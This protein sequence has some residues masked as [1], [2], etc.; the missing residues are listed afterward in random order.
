MISLHIFSADHRH[1]LL[2]NIQ[3]AESDCWM[4]LPKENH[5]P[6]INPEESVLN[7]DPLPPSLRL[8]INTEHFL[9]TYYSNTELMYTITRNFYRLSIKF[10]VQS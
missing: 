2:Q 7:P 3:G 9:K 4:R 1:D 5:M 10:Y 8:C 6:D